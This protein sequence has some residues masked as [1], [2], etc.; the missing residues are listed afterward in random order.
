M[1]Y[2]SGSTAANTVTAANTAAAGAGAAAAGS[3]K[4]VDV[5]AS[6]QY[7]LPVGASYQYVRPDAGST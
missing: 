1:L 4:G 2:L 5:V 3:F 7:D 6:S